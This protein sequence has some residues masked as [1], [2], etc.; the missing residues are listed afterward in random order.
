VTLSYPGAVWIAR[1]WKSNVRT[2]VVVPS[3]ASTLLF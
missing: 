1:P 3:V 2:E